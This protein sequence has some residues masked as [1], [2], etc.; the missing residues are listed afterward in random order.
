MLLLHLPQGLDDILKLV[1]V[2]G[3]QVVMRF[4]QVQTGQ[5]FSLDPF[6]LY[7]EIGMSRQ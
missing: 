6:Q 7:S 4:Q 5:Q 2:V 1:I 3:E